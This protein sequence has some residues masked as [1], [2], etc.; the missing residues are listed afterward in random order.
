MRQFLTISIFIA[1]VGLP[2][3]GVAQWRTDD[4]EQKPTKVY[5]MTFEDDDYPYEEGCPVPK[6]IEQRAL[7][8]DAACMEFEQ[9]HRSG[10]QQ[11]HNPQFIFSTKNNRFLLGI[12]GEINF[13]T[14]YDFKGA[15]DNIDFVP[16]DI[17]M[18]ATYANR[19]RVMMDA[20]TSRL[21]TK[22]IIN[23]DRL[24]R[25]VAFIDMDFR[26]GEEFSYTPHLRAAYVSMLG[27]TAGRDVTTFCDLEAVPDMI[28]HEGP[29]AYNFR[30]ATLL[31]YELDFMQDHFRVGIA[32]EMPKVSGTY[33]E[34]FLSLAQR[35]P[36]IPLYVQYAW[37]ENRQ[38]H[39][40]ASA[41][42]RN[43]YLH[44]ALTNENTSL[45]GWGVQASAH[46]E[47][48]DWVTLYANGIYGEGI[49]PY[50]QDLAGSGLDFT[51]NPED[52]KHIQT[53]PMWAWQASA[54]VDIIPS[55]LWLSGGYSTVKVNQHNGFYAEDQYK[56]GNY[57]FGNIFYQLTSNCRVAAE[58]LHGSRKNMNEAMGEANRLSVM[59]QYN[60]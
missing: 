13:R 48:G 52:A 55:T 47:I 27:F 10:F 53:M 32:A 59:V 22:A 16:Y 11:L 56:R 44:N 3:Q 4:Q 7:A 29:N 49:T 15:V 19:Q 24:G 1:A 50:I 36:D 26:G 33:G 58:Y 37:G 14:S 6:M 2:D 42:F 20:T 30:Y 12:G 34:N 46:V 35:V 28:D 57:I 60:F 51:P 45:F 17:P 41:V 38:S 21:Y 40:R 18:D 25:V 23:S 5:V 39:V 31:R 54:Q 43:M 8:A 9:T